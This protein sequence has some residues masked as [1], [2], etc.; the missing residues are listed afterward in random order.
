MRELFLENFKLPEATFGAFL[1]PEEGTHDPTA[2]ALLGGF[3][4]Q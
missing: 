1:A 3:G 2:E 4:R